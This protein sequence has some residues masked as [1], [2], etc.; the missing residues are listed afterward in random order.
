MLTTL[1]GAILGVAGVA[2]SITIVAVNF[3]SSNY[4]PRLIGNF[5]RDKTNQA[6]L[7]IF[8]ST[9]VYC[10]TV[11]STVHAQREAAEQTFQ[12]FVPQISVLFAI[13]LALVSVGAL[14]GYIHHVPESINIMNLIAGIGRK[15]RQSIVSLLDQEEARENEERTDTHVSAWQTGP[16][17]R[18]GEVSVRTDAAGYLQQLDI[19][20][21]DQLASEHELQIV[22]NRTPGDFLAARRTGDDGP[23]R[24]EGGRLDRPVAEALVHP[25]VQPH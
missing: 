6:V 20:G 9:F 10:I 25:G 17:D 2:F 15:L 7:G 3:A 18:D 24:R 14:I 13:F 8:V 21:L 5:M 16:A 12:A 11:L 4:G 1:A 19:E 22:I 23:P